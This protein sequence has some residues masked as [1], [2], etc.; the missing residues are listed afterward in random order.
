MAQQIK[1]YEQYTISHEGIVVSQKYSKERILKP[2]KATQSQKGYYQ[3]RLFNKEFKKGK[4]HYLHRLVYETF[5]GEIPEGYEIDH[6]D[7]DTSNN[8]ISNLQLITNEQN[9][10]KYHRGRNPLGVDIRE[11]R[12]EIIK[13]Y[14]QIGDLPTLAEKWGASINGVYRVIKN[15]VSCKVNGKNKL[16]VW[17]ES[18]KDEWTDLDLRNENTRKKL[19]LKPIRRNKK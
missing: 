5:V 14:I 9:L 10:K 6:I 16:K 17:D 2:Q 8:H 15:Q 11:H 12:D 13:D 7:A 18:I 4:L 19:G 1:N 3:V